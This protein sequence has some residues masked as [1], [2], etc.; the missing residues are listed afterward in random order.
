VLPAVGELAA[1]RANYGH[2]ATE[3]PQPLRDANGNIVFPGFP[4]DVLYSFRV[5]SV[6]T[7]LVLWS[8]LGLIFAPSAERV[9]GHRSAP[10]ARLSALV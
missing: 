4:A 1:N 7:Q 6:A 8:A 2:F 10:A 5:Y 9:L 3:T